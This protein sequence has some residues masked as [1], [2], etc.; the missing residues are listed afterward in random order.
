MPIPARTETAKA[1]M[2]TILA[3][4]LKRLKNGKEGISW[5]MI[6]VEK[7]NVTAAMSM[8]GKEDLFLARIGIRASKSVIMPTK[9]VVSQKFPEGAIRKS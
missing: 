6:P 2:N 3:G 9:K 8:K 5:L 4:T 1:K 7:R